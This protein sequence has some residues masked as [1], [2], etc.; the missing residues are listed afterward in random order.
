MITSNL[1]SNNEKQNKKSKDLS[2]KK[3]PPQTKSFKL[4]NIHK[5]RQNKFLKL[6]GFVWSYLHLSIRINDA[7]CFCTHTIIVRLRKHNITIRWRLRNARC[8]GNESV[9]SV[10]SVSVIIHTTWALCIY[11]IG[12]NVSCLSLRRR[13]SGCIKSVSDLSLRRCKSGCIKSVPGK[14]PC[15]YLRRWICWLVIVV[16]R[17]WTVI[18]IVIFIII[19]AIETIIDRSRMLDERK[20]K[21]M[22]F[23]HSANLFFYF[24]FFVRL[25][26]FTQWII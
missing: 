6:P 17:N 2:Y 22:V 7:W 20:K 23:L 14:C 21:W 8:L 1:H 11:S 4:I 15:L 9:S 19:I 13:K 18:I 12:K 5:E 3:N 10:S 24:L 16:E 25:Q 26:H